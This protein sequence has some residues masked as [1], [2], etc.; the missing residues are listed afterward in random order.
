MKRRLLSLFLALTLLLSLCVPTAWALE[1]TSEQ[2]KFV[3]D[4]TGYTGEITNRL[5]YTP[6]G[7]SSP[8]PISITPGQKNEFFVES[9]GAFENTKLYLATAPARWTVSVTGLADWNEYLVG[10]TLYFNKNTS[11]SSNRI[12]R[13]SENFLQFFGRSIDKIL[14]PGN[15]GSGG[16]TVVITPVFPRANILSP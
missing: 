2:I 11:S 12:F 13:T 8:T 9:G 14:G 16:Q 6:S 10:A 1:P 7:S 5:Q 4:L 3:I 15:W